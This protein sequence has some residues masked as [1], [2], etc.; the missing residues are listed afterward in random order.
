MSKDVRSKGW[1]TSDFVTLE[2]NLP[3][4]NRNERCTAV[5]SRLCSYIPMHRLKSLSLNCHM[6]Q[7]LCHITRCA[8][9]V[10]QLG[11]SHRVHTNCKSQI[12]ISI[13]CHTAWDVMTLCLYFTLVCHA[14]NV[15]LQAQWLDIHNT[16]T[17]MQHCCKM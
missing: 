5:N 4:I 11:V 13:F 2:I 1:K 10:K 8:L 16:S 15:K 14:S 17:W 9:S 12:M 3:I 7:T 6:W